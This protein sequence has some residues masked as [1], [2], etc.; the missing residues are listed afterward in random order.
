M[1]LYVL[2]LSAYNIQIGPGLTA[3]FALTISVSLLFATLEKRY[4]ETSESREFLLASSVEMAATRRKLLILISLGFLADWAYI[5]GVPFISGSSYRGFDPSAATQ[6]GVG[7]PYL[8]V[9]TTALAVF[10]CIYLGYIFSA[11]RSFPVLL[12]FAA[13]LMLLLLSQARGFAILSLFTLAIFMSWNSKR[14]HRR[15]G[16]TVR[17]A[18]GLVVGLICVALF[19]GI[20]G[21]LRL[22]EPWD[23]YEKFKAIAGF[24][25]PSMGLVDSFSWTYTYLTSPLSNLA[26]QTQTVPDANSIQSIVYGF[27]PATFSKHLDTAS[28]NGVYVVDYLNA[29]TGFADFYSL[30]GWAGLY[31]SFVLMLAYFALWEF[32]VRRVGHLVEMMRGIFVLFVVANVFYDPFSNVA[33]AYAPPLALLAAVVHKRISAA[34][35]SLAKGDGDQ[36]SRRAGRSPIASRESL[37]SLRT[38][39]PA[40]STRPL[41]RGPSASA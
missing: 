12:E 11:S 7:I 13:C 3:F 14:S 2:R 41:G 17:R 5:G 24:S 23:N 22:G 8:H 18:L 29:S 26:L 27:M 34:R 28:F 38:S 40:A 20:L 9:A 36:V 25:G 30:G 6:A 32:A 16:L 31:A 4:T 37:P 1:G 15:G 19:M 10:F 35:T 21:N 33:L 39:G